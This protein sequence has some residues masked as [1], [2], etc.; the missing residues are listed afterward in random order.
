MMAAIWHASEDGSIERFEPRANPVHDR[1]E[2]LVWGIDDDHVAAYWFP[3]ECPRGT[4]WATQ[5]TNDDD[6]ER[7]LAGDRSRRVHA[8]QSDWLD[9]VRSAC[10][11]AY[12]FLRTRSSRTLARQATGSLA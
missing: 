7:F 2:P 3:P 10:V 5:A 9:A 4:F 12:V 6:V 8:I 1:A 11:F